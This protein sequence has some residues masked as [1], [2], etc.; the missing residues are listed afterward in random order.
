MD[1]S[2]FRATLDLNLM[3]GFHLIRAFASGMLARQWGGI[4]NIA[5]IINDGEAGQADYA[6]AKTAVASLTRSPVAEFAPH[7]TVKTVAPG[8]SNISVT[9][10]IPQD[11]A[12]RLV[13][14]ALN[15]RMAEPDETTDAIA[16]FLSDSARFVTGEMLSVSGDIRPHL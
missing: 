9:R 13:A 15:R 5:S 10:N 8:L 1:E 16:C 4:V 3:P 6:A 14:R 12:A 11:E 7:V 2:Q